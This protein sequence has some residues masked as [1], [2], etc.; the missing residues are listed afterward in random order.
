MGGGMKY[1]SFSTGSHGQEAVAQND[2]VKYLEL[3]FSSG[4]SLVFSGVLM[5]CFYEDMSKK[6]DEE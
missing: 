3:N 5:S 2:N 1:T 6:D 4:I